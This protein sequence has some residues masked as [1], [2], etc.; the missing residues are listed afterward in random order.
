[1]GMGFNPVK[2]QAGDLLNE[3]LPSYLKADVEFRYRLEDKNNFGFDKAKDDD[4]VHKLYRTRVSL[5]LTPIK[6]ATFFIQGQDARVGHLSIG[7]KT[8]STYSNLWD[9]RQLYAKYEEEVLVDAIGL[10]KIAFQGGRQEFAYGAERLIGGFNWSNIAQTFD[11]GRARFHFSVLHLQLDILT[12]DKVGFRSPQ[13]TEAG[14]LFDASTKDRMYAYYAT[15]KVFHETLIENYL[16]HRITWKNISF[17]P[18]GS[19]EIDDYTFGG[20]IKNKLPYNFDYEIEGA[21][22][23]GAFSK[24][25]V[26]AAMAVGILGYTFDCPW[27]P[28]TAFEFDYASGGKPNGKTMNTFDNLYPT[29]HAK[30]GNMDFISLQNMFDYHYQISINPMKKLKLQSDFHLLYLATAKDSFYSAARGVTRTTPAGLVGVSNHVGN[31][32]DLSADYKLNAYLGF[33]GGYSHLFPGV[34]LKDTGTNNAADFLYFQ[35]TVA[36]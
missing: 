30:Y 8:K 23:W 6:Q 18:N 28:R 22:Q 29:N 9:I 31:E 24:K 15:A 32:I 13:E 3:H 36:F 10:N 19:S 14:D 25:A 21:G 11:G 27:Q 33:Q 17:G 7:S 4:D 1:M 20:R 16:I 12:G 5:G 34:Y 35:T 2:A 26:R